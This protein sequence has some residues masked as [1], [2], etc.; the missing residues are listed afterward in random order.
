[1]AGGPGDGRIADPRGLHRAVRF[2]HHR[3][4]AGCRRD[5]PR[6][7]EHGRVRDG[8]VE[9]VDRAFGPTA[10]SLGSR[11][12]SRWLVGWV[13]GGRR[14]LPLPAVDRHRHGRLDPPAGGPVRDRRAQADLRTSQP[15]RDRRVRLVARP[16][17]PVRSR[18]ARCG[19]P[20][21]RRSPAATNAIRRP[22]RC[23]S[24]TSCCACR[25]ATTKPRRGSAASGSGCRASTSSRAWSRA[26][27]PGYGEAVA[28][29]EGAGATIEDVSSAPHRLRPRDVLHRRARGGVGQPGPLRRRPVRALGPPRR[30]LHRR[31]PADPGRGLRARG[32]AADHARHVCPLGGLLRR[33]LPQGAEGPDAHQDGL[34]HG[35]GGRV[36]RPRRADVADG[37]LPVRRADRRPGGDVPLRRLHAAGQHGRPAGHLDPVRALGRA[38]GRPPVH[39]RAV[40]G[41]GTVPFRT[42]LRGDHR[43]GP[44][45]GVSS[46]PI[47]SRQTTRQA[48]PRP[49]AQPPEC[50][51]P[52]SRPASCRRL[53]A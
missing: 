10:Q 34:R 23:R 36:R 42:S 4:P 16:D 14:G 35:L 24:P 2:P 53:R 18:R 11:A 49:S 52:R 25:P 28:A 6:Q 47:L 19:G 30:R 3:T 46:P 8:L 39:R 12:G 51:P 45:G 32:E 15:L 20:A 22:R 21:A 50:R 40:V 48:R 33:L 37:R 7:D 41:A 1:M 29:I 13:G 43:A 44:S 38:P 26:S 17:R 9:R 27:R 31:L 5:H